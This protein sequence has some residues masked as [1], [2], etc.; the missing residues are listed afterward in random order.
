MLLKRLIVYILANSLPRTPSPSQGGA[1]INSSEI[2]HATRRFRCL[3]ET[4]LKMSSFVDL[5]A[6]Q[7]NLQLVTALG[8][9]VL[10]HHMENLRFHVDPRPTVSKFRRRN[11]T[12]LPGRRGDDSVG[13]WE[14]TTQSTRTQRIDRLDLE[15]LF[16][17]LFAVALRCRACRY[18]PRLLAWF[19]S[20]Q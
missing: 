10:S 1:D 12:T 17:Q 4:P 3:S 11:A 2:G 20:F 7:S 16:L 8:I 15:F 14:R 19:A 6:N 5:Q 9:A 18:F 13:V